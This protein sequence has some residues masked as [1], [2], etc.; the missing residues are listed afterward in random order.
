MYHF[1]PSKLNIL[2]KF[3]EIKCWE[4]MWNKWNSYLVNVLENNLALS[5]QRAYTL[6]STI[7]P[8]G[9][10]PRETRVVH[11]QQETRI[12]TFSI[13]A[14]TK[15]KTQAKNPYPK[16]EKNFNENQER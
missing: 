9:I 15:Q 14:K 6:N 2:H 5:S 13:V 7:P 1:T 11:V 10:Y 12:A 3:Y 4:K 8:L 16:L